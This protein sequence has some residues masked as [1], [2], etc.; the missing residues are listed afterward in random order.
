MKGNAHLYDGQ[1]AARHAV[2]VDLSEDRNALV[3]TGDSLAAP[4]VWPLPDLRALGDHADPSQIV[5]TRHL[6]TPDE[7]PR[8]PARLVVEDPE[9]VAWLH[10]TRPR[11]HRKDLRDGTG[12]RI[13]LRLGGALAA[14]AAM[15]FV[16]LPALANTLAGLLPLDKEIAFGQGVKA[17]MER[18]LGASELGALDCDAPAGRAALDRMVARLTGGQDLGYPLSVS[19]IDH[20][21]MN[22]FAAPGGQIVVLRGLLDKAQSPDVVAAVLAHEIGHVVHR[23]PTRHALRTAGSVGLLGLV[24]GDFTGGTVMVLLAER[25]INASYSQDAEA[26]ADQY[27]YDMLIAAGLPPSALAEMFETFR[28]EFGDVEGPMAHFASH[29]RLATRIDAANA[30][31]PQETPHRPALGTADWQA[32]R[33]ICKDRG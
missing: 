23:D 30:A 8:D 10:R 4:V 24:F 5:L 6:D 20:K 22:A 13:A 1:S 25:L 2:Q 7:S 16:I 29:P 33:T 15:I 21:M 19:V 14:V 31:S 12:R 9:M 11:L 3:I 26:K 32:L 28:K 18:F 27:A 17:Q